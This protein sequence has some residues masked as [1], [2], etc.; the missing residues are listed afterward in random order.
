MVLHRGEGG[1]QS[2]PAVRAVGAGRREGGPEVHRGPGAGQ[3]LVGQRAQFEALRD[4]VAGRQQLVGVQRLQ[5]LRPPGEYPEVRAE[6]LVRR[7]DQGVRAEG[8]QVD[9]DVRGVVHRVDV[10]QR[11]HGVRQGGQ[12]RHV[13]AGA[14]EVGGGRHRDQTGARREH[15]LDVLRAQFTGDGVEAGPPHGGAR[16]LG[17]LDPR[18][19]VGVVVQPRDHHLVARAPVLGEG[20]GQVVHQLGGAAA[21]HHGGGRGVEEVAHGVPGPGHDVVGVAL[22]LG[23]TAAVGQRTGEGL[24]DRLRDGRW[25]LRAA[26]G[27]EAG[28][29]GGEQGGKGGAHGGGVERRVEGRVEG[30][31]E[32]HQGPP[33]RVEGRLQAMI[34]A[35]CGGRNVQVRTL[36]G[37]PKPLRVRTL[38]RKVGGL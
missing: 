30:R 29:V 2:R 3:Q 1:D 24:G 20:A 37:S 14:V 18:A 32:G 26:G 22:R 16:R 17:G 7:T 11:A 6:E 34:A 10:Q 19:D 31:L 4:G 36:G 9:G 27:V 12:G 38:R 5:Q 28:P 35:V 25:R 23:E 33:G 13:G 15:R 8:G 21:E